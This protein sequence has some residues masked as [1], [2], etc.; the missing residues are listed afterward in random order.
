[1]EKT[2]K[3]SILISEETHKLLKEYCDKNFIKIN[4]WTN[5]IL[6]EH[7]QKLNNKKE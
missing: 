4:E 5:N 1:M 2:K 7:L 3:K 6:L